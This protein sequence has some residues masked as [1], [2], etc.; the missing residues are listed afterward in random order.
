MDKMINVKRTIAEFKRWPGVVDGYTNLTLFTAFFMLYVYILLAQQEIPES[1][2]IDFMVRS[3]LLDQ[4][5]AL[6]KVNTEGNP[7]NHPEPAK[8]PHHV[9]YHAIQIFHDPHSYSSESVD[10]TRCATADDPPGGA[11]SGRVRLPAQGVR[12][13]QG[14]VPGILQQRPHSYLHRRHPEY[15]SHSQAPKQTPV[16][17]TVSTN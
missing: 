16:S 6:A 10:H 4:D 15:L 11:R 5:G 17:L 9:Q 13:G 2:K 7:S 12:F 8:P 3:A 14:G 1:H